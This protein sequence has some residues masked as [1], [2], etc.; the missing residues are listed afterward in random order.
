[1]VIEERIPNGY[2]ISNTKH[3]ERR[4]EGGYSLNQA[5]NVVAEP[6]ET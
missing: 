1:M 4:G 2:V 3:P 6:G 5:S